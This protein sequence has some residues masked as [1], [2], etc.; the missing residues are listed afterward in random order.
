MIELLTQILLIDD[1]KKL[2]VIVYFKSFLLKFNRQGNT[3]ILCRL[4]SDPG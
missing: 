1:I 4:K 2:L 3:V